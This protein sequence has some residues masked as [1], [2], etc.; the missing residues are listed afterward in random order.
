MTSGMAALW[1][2]IGD[3]LDI[4]QQPLWIASPKL[5]NG[6]TNPLGISDGYWQDTTGPEE[7]EWR[8]VG[9]DMC[10]DEFQTQVLAK[11]DVTHFLI[12]EGPWAG[13]E[14]KALEAA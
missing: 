5:I 13:E 12:P 4:Y 6:D 10:N 1:R 7:G 9:F 11:G 8:C 14:L 2:P 3:L